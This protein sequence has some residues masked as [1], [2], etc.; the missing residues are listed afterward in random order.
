VSRLCDLAGPDE[1]LV[2]TPEDPA[3]EVVDVR[4]LDRAVPVTRR[5]LV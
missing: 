2:T 4:G 1:L 5:A 3:A